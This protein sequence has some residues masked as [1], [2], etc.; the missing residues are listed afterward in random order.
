MDLL[1]R[2]EHRLFVTAA[3]IVILLRPG[4]TLPTAV[5]FAFAGKHLHLFAYGVGGDADHFVDFISGQ[6][7]FLSRRH[8]RN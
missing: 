7:L 6:A 4:L 2:V 1:V 3:L 5:T 8:P